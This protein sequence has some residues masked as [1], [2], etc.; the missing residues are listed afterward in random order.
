MADPAMLAN[1]ANCLEAFK[2]VQPKQKYCS[3]QCRKAGEQA[4]YR[5]L[6]HPVSGLPTATIG[7][8]HELAVAIDLLK[9]GYSVYSSL[10][11]S[12][13]GD[14]VIMNGGKTAK[15]VEVTTGKRSPT[16]NLTYPAHKK[17]SGTFD[18]IAVVEPNGRITYLPELDGGTDARPQLLS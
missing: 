10:S 16:G 6:N 17:H 1:C 11:A 18:L 7:A 5:R 12:S 9:K 2:L 14:L 8:M 4:A 3:R 13:P 15:L